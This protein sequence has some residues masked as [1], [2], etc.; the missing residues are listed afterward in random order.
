[1]RR[2][3]HFFFSEVVKIVDGTSW[4]LVG[5]LRFTISASTGLSARLCRRSCRGSPGC[6][7][8]CRPLIG[9]R[10]IRRFP[11]WRGIRPGLWRDCRRSGGRRSDGCCRIRIRTRLRIDERRIRSPCYGH[12]TNFLAARFVGCGE[13]AV[14]TGRGGCRCQCRIR[15]RTQCRRCVSSF[16]GLA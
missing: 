10:C 4:R 3:T 12:L 9:C 13:P 1:M 6:S 15:F 2:K 8:L 14:Q 5:W 16:S 7:G 11:C